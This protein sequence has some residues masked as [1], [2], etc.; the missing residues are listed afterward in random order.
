MVRSLRRF[1]ERGQTLACTI[2][3]PRAETFALFNNL[4]LIKAGETMYN[5]PIPQILPFLDACGVPID[6]SVNPADLVVDLTHIKEDGDHAAEAV[7]ADDL[8][9]LY[10]HSELRRSIDTEL[11]TIADGTHPEVL[12]AAALAEPDAE[13]R[14]SA[15]GGKRGGGGGGEPYYPNSLWTQVSV[16]VRRAYVIDSR[17]F[18][19]K[20]TWFL[21]AFVLALNA[22]TYYFVV[23]PPDTA[24]P[25]QL[26]LESFAAA[27][28]CRAPAAMPSADGAHT[29]GADVELCGKSIFER[30][31]V[32]F[33]HRGFIFLVINALFINEATF[34]PAI[35][36]DKRVFAREHGARAYSAL[37]W[38]TAWLVKMGLT[39]AIKTIVYTPCFYFLGHLLQG[40]HPYL[41]ACF[42]AGGMGFAGSAAAM[43]IASTVPSLGAATTAFACAV[44]IYQNVCGFFLTIQVHARLA[45]AHA[46]R[47]RVALHRCCRL[48]LRCRL[49]RRYRRRPN[50]FLAPVTML[51]HSRRRG[52]RCPTTSCGSH[53]RPSSPT[54]TRRWST[55]SRWAPRSPRPS[56]H[57]SRT[58]SCGFSWASSTC[59]RCS[60]TS[61]R[62]A[63]RPSTTR[64][65][66]NIP[67]Q[68]ARRAPTPMAASLRWV[69]CTSCRH[70]SWAC[71]RH[72]RS[73]SLRR[74]LP[75]APRAPTPS[76]RCQ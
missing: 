66:P 19:Y 54:A 56:A 39:A 51:H 55:R 76:R 71:P 61:S 10:A 6:A 53:G 15:S 12:E 31:N 11:G 47:T 22:T 3:Q 5:G 59:G 25:P 35:Q 27:Q 72:T 40:V 24:Q 73:P 50:C 48:H 13:E 2:H 26:Y 75:G 18:G 14:H 57:S 4:L 46:S 43:L 30:M 1:A 58:A 44:L 69:R 65:K 68:R 33:A 38:H 20:F 62:G 49:H 29:L 64:E 52:R 70:S 16:L 8:V 36:F 45:L 9:R 42:A 41:A 37:A 60:P 23:K 63:A 74:R 32:E 67:G 17:D 28:T 34:V 7:T 21:N